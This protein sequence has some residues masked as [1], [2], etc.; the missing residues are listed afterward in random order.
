[1]KEM[2]K[3]FKKE[4]FLKKLSRKLYWEVA[5]G[6]VNINKAGAFVDFID[7]LQINC[8]KKVGFV[9]FTEHFALRFA[10]SQLSFAGLKKLIYVAVNVTNNP[11][12]IEN[13]KLK[14][15]SFLP[16]WDNRLEIRL[17]KNTGYIVFKFWEDYPHIDFISCG[18][19]G[20]RDR[21]GEKF[22]KYGLKNFQKRKIIKAQ[23]EMI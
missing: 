2:V 21:E 15:F 22:K 19:P 14:G 10:S 8:F 3:K 4:L 16:G 12:I 18:I 17:P 9:K 1:M 6:V 20:E 23:K 11:A 13:Y 5:N 7:E